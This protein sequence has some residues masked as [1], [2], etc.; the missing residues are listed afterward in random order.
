MA[1]NEFFTVFKTEYWQRDK[2]S[3]CFQSLVDAMGYYPVFRY[4]KGQRIHKDHL[5]EA[6]T[7]IRDS[8]N[9]I[10]EEFR[11]Q[12]E[13]GLTYVSSRYRERAYLL[14]SDPQ[15]T[16]VI[17]PMLEDDPTFI[18]DPEAEHLAVGEDHAENIFKWRKF[19][20]NRTR[21]FWKSSSPQGR[22]VWHKTFYAMDKPSFY[23]GGDSSKVLLVLF[24]P[25]IFVFPFWNNDIE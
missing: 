21:W 7:V 5:R 24:P 9:A 23:G 11:P 15:T 10:L 13:G 6:M 12:E 17:I 4:F 19:T 1:D 16:D 18:E 2:E 22:L 25:S 3:R 20:F 8:A 14:L